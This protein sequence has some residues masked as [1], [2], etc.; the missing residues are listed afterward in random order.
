MWEDLVRTSLLR[1]LCAPPVSAGTRSTSGRRGA[2]HAVTDRN[3]TTQF[4]ATVDSAGLVAFS[5]GPASA[6]DY[7]DMNGTAAGRHHAE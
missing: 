3:H 5:I 1:D 2:G 7:Q 6:A 4:A